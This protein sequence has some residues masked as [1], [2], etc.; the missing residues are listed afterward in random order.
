MLHCKT[1]PQLL[2]LLDKTKLHRHNQL[3][4]HIEHAVAEQSVPSERVIRSLSQIIEWRATPKTLRCDNKPEYISKILQDWARREGIEV[5]YIQ[6]GNPQHYA[7]MERYNRTVHYDWL[8][9]ELFQTIEEMQEAATQW[10]W[11]YNKKRPNMAIGGITR[12]QKLV[13]Q[14]LGFTSATC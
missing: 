10:L 9:Q 8:A 5:A 3:S 1:C 14:A 7:Y 12:A 4:T 2:Q 13:L 6:P 11:V